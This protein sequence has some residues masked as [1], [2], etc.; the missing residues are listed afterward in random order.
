MWCDGKDFTTIM[1]KYGKYFGPMKRQGTKGR[2]M[3]VSPSPKCL[4]LATPF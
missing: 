2:E 4:V 1:E 3:K